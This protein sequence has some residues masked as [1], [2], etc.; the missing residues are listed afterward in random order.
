VSG[1]FFLA[2]RYLLWHRWKTAILVLAVTLV[3]EQRVIGQY[4]QLKKAQ[5][6]CDPVVATVDR[7]MTD[8]RWH[9]Q[10]VRRALVKLG[11]RFGEDVVRACVARYRVADEAVF[12]QLSLEHGHRLEE[13]MP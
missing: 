3:F 12:K 5:I 6:A 4:A 13:V 9:I 2:W 1:V 10:W 7:I 11:D 8:E